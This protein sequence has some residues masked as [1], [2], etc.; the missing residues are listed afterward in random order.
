MSRRRLPVLVDQA[1]GAVQAESVEKGFSFERLV[2]KQKHVSCTV[3]C[4]HCCHHPFEVSLLEAIPIYR[5]L[6]QKGRW[7]PSFVKALQEHVEKTDYLP[8]VTWLLLN[9]PCPLLVNSRCSVYEVRPFH[10]RTTWS[11]GDPHY[12]KGERFGPDT[13]LVAK[14]DLTRTFNQY[15]KL[16]AKQVGMPFYTLPLS[17]ALLWA[18]KLV[19]GELSLHDATVAL[20]EDFEKK[21]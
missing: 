4:D 19:G 7:T 17:K 20:L 8:V 21:A 12:C 10:C 1:I 9:I 15:Q 13:A 6:V 5:H 2:R 14:D 11:V 18:A 16:H 3:G